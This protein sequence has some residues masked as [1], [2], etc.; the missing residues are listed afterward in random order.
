MSMA[1]TLAQGNAEFL[2]TAVLMQMVK[3]GTPTI[4]ATLA[5]VADMRTG[6]YTS[7]GIECGMLHMAFAQLAHFYNVPCGG[8]IG[9]TNSKV[10]DAQAGYETGMSAMGGLVSGM[11]MFNIGGLIDALKTFDFAK[12]VIDDEVGQ[13]MKRVKR[14]VKFS[15]DELAVN[16]IKEIGPGGSYIVAKHTISRM[17]I[18]AVMTK[19]A[20]RDPRTTWEKKGAMDIHARAMKRAREIMLSNPASVLPPEVDEK[21]RAE[22]PGMVPGELKPME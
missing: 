21:L 3:E 7:G 11:D 13:M 12:A 10:N 4:Y 2:A 1:G 15:E 8:Y 22:F 5:T 20:D 9:L 14:G 17:K 19:I 6:A 16:L 18:E